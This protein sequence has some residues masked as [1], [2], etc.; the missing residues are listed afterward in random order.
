MCILQEDSKAAEGVSLASAALDSAKPLVAEAEEAQ[1]AAE[2]AR[3]EMKNISRSA[4]I[5]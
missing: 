3:S 2:A 1:K 4:S 5:F